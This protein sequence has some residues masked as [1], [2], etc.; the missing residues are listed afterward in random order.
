MQGQSALMGKSFDLWHKLCNLIIFLSLQPD[1]MDLR[2]FKVWI[3]LVQIVKVGNIQG[4]H[5]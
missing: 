3:L 2:Y 1:V 4:K 5:H